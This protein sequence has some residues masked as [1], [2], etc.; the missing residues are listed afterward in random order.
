MTQEAFEAEILGLTGSMYRV[1]FALLPRHQD[2]QDAV[3]SAILKAWQY[4]DRLRDESKFKSI[5]PR[6]PSLGILPAHRHKRL[7][8]RA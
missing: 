8:R 1:S 3:Q 4:K 2:R 5:R 7:H 6:L